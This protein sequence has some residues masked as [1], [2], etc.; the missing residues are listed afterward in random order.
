MRST[1]KPTFTASRK[2][3]QPAH[4][5]RLSKRVAELVACSRADAERYIEGGWVRV[6]GE[7]IELPGHRVDQEKIAL[8]PHAT[9]L[10]QPSITIV[11]HKPPDFDANVH[12]AGLRPALQLLTAAHHASTDKSGTRML[13][14]HFVDLMSVTP[15]E[16]GASGLLVFTKDW[17]VQ[18]KLV[19]DA[20]RVEHEVI[21]DVRGDVTERALH[22]LNKS[23]VIDDRAMLPAKVSVTHQ[24]E[25]LAGDGYNAHTAH[26]AHNPGSAHS[27]RSGHNSHNSHNP[28]VTGLR[29]AIKGCYPGQIKQMCAHVG[30]QVIG[31]KRIRV[32]R[33]MLSNLPQGQWRYVTALEKF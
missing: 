32:G 29:F 31:M 5:I 7:V 13:K 2:P 22:Y 33:V 1:L 14:Q 16:T 10:A 15:I 25:A 21:V 12:N 28:V 19:E 11:L 8:D 24:S 30:L 6:N 20:A 27:A 23:Q 17:T 4:G 9:L 18:R 3:V 26:N